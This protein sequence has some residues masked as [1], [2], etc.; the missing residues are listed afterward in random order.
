MGIFHL[1]ANNSAQIT[2]TQKNQFLKIASPL[3]NVIQ[4][5]ERKKLLENISVKNVF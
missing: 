3:T 4:V 2:A 5:Q 1:C